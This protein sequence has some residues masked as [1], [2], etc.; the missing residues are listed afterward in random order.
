[1][2][3]RT[4]VNAR[5]CSIFAVYTISPFLCIEGIHVWR[6]LAFGSHRFGPI[7]VAAAQTHVERWELPSR[8]APRPHESFSLRSVAML[9]MAR[10]PNGWQ[11]RLGRQIGESF[12]E[13]WIPI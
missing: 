11:T 7:R 3:R 1:M 9:Q 10:H 6:H 12:A 13:V 5:E 4:P 2:A 8:S